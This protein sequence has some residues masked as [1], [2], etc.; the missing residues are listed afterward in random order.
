M[1]WRKPFCNGNVLS[2]F[3]LQH[4]YADSLIRRCV[5]GVCLLVYFTLCRCFGVHDSTGR[6]S[7]LPGIKGSTGFEC[8]NYTAKL[9]RIFKC[10]KLWLII[11]GGHLTTI[12]QLSAGSKLKEKRRKKCI[13]TNAQSDAELN[14]YILKV[15]IKKRNNIS[16]LSLRID[17]VNVFK[18]WIPRYLKTTYICRIWRKRRTVKGKSE[19]AIKNK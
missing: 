12:R 4:I 8:S 16:P 10:G 14:F 13:K 17:T 5:V 19:I 15:D 7:K 9:L 11:D 18:L 3:T 6:S 1:W 2:T